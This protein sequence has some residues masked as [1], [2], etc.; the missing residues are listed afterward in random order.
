MEPWI[1]HDYAAWDCKK[2]KTPEKAL[3]DA[4]WCVRLSTGKSQLEQD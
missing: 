2:Y 1:L 4:R 3:K